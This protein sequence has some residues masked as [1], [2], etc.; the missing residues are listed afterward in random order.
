VLTIATIYLTKCVLAARIA[1]E[2]GE[3]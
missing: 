1:R 3:P 2:R